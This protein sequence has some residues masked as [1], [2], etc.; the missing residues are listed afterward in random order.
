[1]R[2]VPALPRAT[3]GKPGV[4][5]HQIAPASAIDQDFR[6][7]KN[8]LFDIDRHRAPRAEWG[9]A[10]HQVAA[11]PVG[12]F[13]RTGFDRLGADLPRQILGGDLAVAMHEHQQGLCVLVLHHQRLDD[14]KRVKPQH[15]CAVLGTSVFQV[16]IRVFGKCHLVRFEHLGGRSLGDVFFFGHGGIFL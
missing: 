13:G 10:T 1:M 16:F 5:P 2:T 11:V 3:A 6:Q 4:D 9:R 12:D 15:L 8:G 7:R 14:R